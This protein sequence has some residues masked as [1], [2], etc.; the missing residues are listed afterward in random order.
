MTKA[1]KAERDEAVRE[2]R[3]MLKPGDTVY[4][5]L[6]HTSASGMYRALDVHVMRDNEPRRITWKV[7]KALEV[8]YDLRREALGVSGCGMDMGFHVV[9]NLGYVLYPEGFQCI[10]RGCPSSDHSNGDRDYSPHQHS[11]GGYALQHQ[12]M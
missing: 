3:E 8:K 1:Q 9:Y 11:D 2:L 6:R 7:G 12:W 10:G 5:I 4:T